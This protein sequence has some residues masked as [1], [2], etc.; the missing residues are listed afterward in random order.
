MG[1]ELLVFSVVRAPV[2]V[3]THGR[4]AGTGWRRECISHASRITVPPGPKGSQTRPTP[5]A[6]LCDLQQRGP[7]HPEVHALCAG[8]GRAVGAGVP[9]G[10][11]SSLAG[12]FLDVF[13]HIIHLRPLLLHLWFLHTPMYSN[14]FSFSVLFL[15]WVE[16]TGYL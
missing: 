4:P 6:Q 3:L 16:G 5:Q 1:R 14:Q 13:I 7:H 11:S 8:G 9:P 10:P 12:L 2:S 15:Y